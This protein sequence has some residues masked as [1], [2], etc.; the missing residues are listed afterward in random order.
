MPEFEVEKA[1]GSV[2]PDVLAPAGAA[3][4]FPGS[5]VA[6]AD[7][8]LHVTTVSVGGEALGRKHW[9]GTAAAVSDPGSWQ[10]PGTKLDCASKMTL[11]EYAFWHRVELHRL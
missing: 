11:G 7:P 8:D 2:S 5:A 9:R 10:S 6:E 1:T 4:G 3:I